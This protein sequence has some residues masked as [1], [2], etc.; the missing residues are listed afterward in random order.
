MKKTISLILL[1]VL[2]INTVIPVFGYFLA[3][4]A[5]RKEMK[6]L[7]MSSVPLNE[8]EVIRV[9]A[10]IFKTGGKYLQHVEKNEIRYKGSMY[11]I[12]KVV[13]IADTAVIYAVNDK[14]EEKLMEKFSEHIKDFLTD[15]SSSLK[16]RLTKL[17][18][19]FN[20]DYIDY[21]IKTIFIES[22]T[23]LLYI[24][25]PEQTCSLI[26]DIPYPPPKQL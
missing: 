1:I 17:L 11:D 26:M 2:V 5:I 6:G 23:R 19:T 14:K 25:Y 15:N 20:F 3:K 10:T 9:P 8:L 22:F 24:I 12:V 7:V 21:F 18:K 16:N 4:S 13:H